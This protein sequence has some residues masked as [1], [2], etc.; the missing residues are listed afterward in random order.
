[1]GTDKLDIGQ[2]FDEITE[3]YTEIMDTMVPHYR[4]L[5]TT[6]FDS[7]PD[8]LEVRSVLD[9]G[10][11]NGNVTAVGMALFPDADYHL[12]DA[13]EKML[14]ECR[15]R[16]QHRAVRYTHGRFQEVLLQSGQYDLILAS[17]SFHHLEEEDKADQFRRLHGALRPGGVFSCADLMID[18][19][20]EEHPALIESWREFVTSNGHS[21]EDWEWLAEHYELYDRP[22]SFDT[23]EG[24]LRESGFSDVVVAWEDG[25]WKC[26]YAFR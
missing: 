4:R 26:I 12:V 22:T 6:M 20:A 18:K 7:L 21:D 17:F 3:G 25:P 9:M 11:G 2:V 16:F 23:Q 8:S 15:M 24:M 1:M 10:C 19:D 5:I 13:S 14:S